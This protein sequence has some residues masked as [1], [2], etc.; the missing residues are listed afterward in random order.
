M[1]AGVAG[2]HPVKHVHLCIG[3]GI[4]VLEDDRL[5]VPVAR[6]VNHHSPKRISWSVDDDGAVDQRTAVYELRERL[7]CVHGAIDRIG[8]DGSALRIPQKVRGEAVGEC[9]SQEGGRRR[10]V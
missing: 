6:R 2:S 10:S 5:V 4:K 1:T 8:L 7:Q 9:V 3:H